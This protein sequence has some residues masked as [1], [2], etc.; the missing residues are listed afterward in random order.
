MKNKI[1]LACLST[2]LLI[3][4]ACS[5]GGG[6][7]SSSPATSSAPAAFLIDN[8]VGGVSFITP[9]KS[10][11]TASDGSFSYSSG[12]ANV[13]FSIG[14]VLLHDFN[15][16]NLNSDKKILITDLVG[17]D[18]ND[19]TNTKVVK[20]LQLLQSLDDDNNASNGITI[21]SA[22]RTALVAS[23]L[24]FSDAGLTINDINTTLTG[25]GE[26][27]VSQDE[28][29]AHFESTLNDDFSY[30]LDSIAP[31]FNS[32]STITINENQT[33]V[34]NLD[35]LDSTAVTLALGGADAASFNISGTTLFFNTAPDFEVITSYALSVTAT[36]SVGNNTTQNVSVNISNLNDN[37]PVISSASSAS[38]NENQTSA[39]TIVASDADANTT[40]SYILSGTDASSFDINSTS[41]VVTFKIAPDYETKSSYTF[42]AIASDGVNSDTQSVSININNIGDVIPTI[43]NF[44]ASIDENA[45]IGTVLGSVSITSSGDA[46]I[47]SFTL[48]DTTNFEVNAS[49]TIKTKTTLDYETTQVYNLTTYAT[50]S[51]GNSISKNV[52]INVNNIPEIIPTI[53]A[54][55]DSVDENASI[56]SVV[57]TISVT[58]P[59][60]SN[61]TSFT[62]SDTTNFLINSS[63]VITT[64]TT[65]DYETTQVYN[66]TTYATNTAGNS[67]SKNVTININNISDVIPIISAFNSSVDE[68]ATVG[69]V[70]GNMTI[71]TSGDSNIT[72]FT[73]SNTTNFEVNAS[74]AIKTKTAL[75]YETTQIYN[76][77]TYATNGAGNSSSVNIVINVN[78][79]ADIVPTITGFS[80]SVDENATVGTVV[81][82]M[83]ITSN[84]DANITSFTLSDTTNFEINASGVVKTKT[85]LDYETT[86]VY[87]LTAYATND[88]GD[89][90]SQNVVIN[91]N[92][93]IDTV[94][95]LTSFTGSVDENVTIGTTVGT[96]SVSDAGDSS[97]T[98]FTLS[99]TTN[100]LISSGGVI[101]TKT[102]LDYETTQVYN[103]SVYATNTAGNSSSVNVTI[104]IGDIY[105]L[106]PLNIPT[107]VIVMN[108]DNYSE[109]DA[110]VWHNKIFN[111]S[112]RSVNNYFDETT[113]G[114]LQIVPITESSGTANDGVIMVSMGKNHPG[115]SDATFRDTEIAAAIQNAEVVNNIDSTYFQALDTDAD[116]G[117]DKRELQIIFI[118]AGGE[119]SYGD[120]AISSI[121][122]HAWSFDSG[123]TLKLHNKYVMKYTG[124]EATSGGY[125]RFGANHG[126]HKAT[127]GIIAHELGHSLLALGD[128]YDNGGGSGLGWYDIMSGGSWAYKSGDTY[129]GETPTQFTAY[130][131]VDANLD[132]GVTDV[133]SSQSLTIK[134]SSRELIKLVTTKSTEYFMLECRDTA[135]ADS[136][137]AFQRVDSTFTTNRLFMA[138][139]HID[140]AK[141]GNTEDGIQTNANHYKVA[142]VEKDTATLL[143]SSTGLTA[144][145]DDV[146]TLGET[147]DSTRTKLYDN[148]VTG[149]SVEVTAEDYTN[150]TMTISITK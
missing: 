39:I 34:I 75:D 61:I 66:L 113:G 43:E 7:G 37:S 87:N 13:S 70:V 73:L 30:V 104:S 16:S 54:F 136:D 129:P 119:T 18:R 67:S 133:N 14:G 17:V 50:N 53:A 52:T 38:V 123:S 29:V 56:G 132:A 110:S 77:T 95:T 88:A 148:T 101:T 111:A 106:V 36:D 83:G 20:I 84:G 145:F 31:I 26:T 102:T 98:S 89:S 4:T 59:G 85:T 118:V 92:N 147:I 21:T 126:A 80:T 15:M 28:A 55:T 6:G 65:L 62:M 58:T 63:G 138:M 78:N 137:I 22:T 142:L 41:G 71:T 44:T 25:I 146:Y 135:K 115:N 45:S 19:S 143:T 33:F 122:A 130:N 74:G 81:G 117:I 64:K 149:Y 109:T 76:L 124:V 120:P 134:C 5:G 49:G 114:K 90:P 150:R 46:N 40:I 2:L 116:G 79:V 3:F 107:V 141:A 140:T 128:Y 86:E 108:W 11:L 121:W 42:N 139:Y 94:P 105:E 27:L 32:P 100:F 57:G 10:G 112:D 12:D 127:I 125:A 82:S 1:L 23:T 91:I 68:N 96:V 103:L 93:I 144:D 51:A 97:V 48:N 8:A 24:D 99:D 9:S 60:D 131:R 35:I 69:S 72:S 47:T